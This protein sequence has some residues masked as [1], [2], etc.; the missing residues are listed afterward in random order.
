MNP[1]WIQQANGMQR[2][3]LPKLL[4]NH[5]Q[6]GSRNQ[7]RHLK[8]KQNDWGQTGLGSAPASW[9]LFDDDGDGI[10]GQDFYPVWYS[11][12]LITRDTR[13]SL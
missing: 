1:N 12:P 9:L 6:H 3:I 4:E 2:N 5:K 11:R 10:I 8:R 13:I 7:E